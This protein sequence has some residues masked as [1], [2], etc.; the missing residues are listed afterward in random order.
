MIV[1][2]PVDALNRLTDERGR[3][4]RSLAMSQ[5]PVCLRVLD[6]LDPDDAGPSG[7]SIG[8]GILD[9]LLRWH[10]QVHADFSDGWALSDVT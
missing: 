6:G 5:R 10:L 3:T 9:S 4:N 1:V 8:K 2:E 7:D